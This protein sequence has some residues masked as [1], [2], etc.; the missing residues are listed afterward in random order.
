MATRFEERPREREPREEEL[1]LEPLIEDRD[2]EKLY[3]MRAWLRDRVRLAPI[4][5]GVF[6][7]FAVQLVLLALGL[8]V[9]AITAA[10]APG[11][12]FPTGLATGLGIWT[13]ISALIALFVGGWFAAFMSGVAGK[14]DGTL[15]GLTVWGLYL[16]L[17]AILSGISGLLGVSSLLG[18]RF[19]QGGATDVLTALNLVTVSGTLTTEQVQN[20]LNFIASAAGWFLLGAI[21]AA[22]AAALGG[23]VGARRRTVQLR[24]RP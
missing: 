2:F 3:G 18:F 20:I 19:G 24:T 9:G 22:L 12:A 4:F 14:L 11:G 15:N 13:A 21:L 8:W 16:F 10:P 7:A 23:W 6:W 17:G 5:A 1:R